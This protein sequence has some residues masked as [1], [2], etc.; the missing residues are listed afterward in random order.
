MTAHSL[1]PS[2]SHARPCADLPQLR[3]RPAIG[4][5]AGSGPEAG[6]DL[7]A[8]ILQH[9]RRRLGAG[10]RGD[11]D[12]PE[13][14]VVSQ[15]ALGLSMELERTEAP[16][17]AAL[18]ASARALDGRVQA[19]A[20]ACNTLNLFAGRLHALGLRARLLSFSEVV[21]RHLQ[22]RA[23][24]HGVCVLGARPV[25]ELGA[26]SPYRGLC[27]Q[28]EVERLNEAQIA[29]LHALIYDVKFHGPQ[30]PGLADRLQA[31]LAGIRSRTVL[32]AC[33][34]L[35]LISRT[36]HA[37]RDLVD[38]TDVVAQA[39]LDDIGTPAAAQGA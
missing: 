31:L 20:I 9:N 1:L 8:K 10:F 39:L 33:T 30:A 5:I 2:S 19:Y 25:A 16:V 21:R 13:V 36:G 4:I 17:W 28:F 27:D 34:E 22:Q 18:E 12:A 23:A 37:P 11:V 35:P 3:A 7:W 6:L 15:P 26:L 38:V 24:T 32:L 14:H 29:Q